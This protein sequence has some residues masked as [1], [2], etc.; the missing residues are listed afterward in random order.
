MYIEVI[1]RK[2]ESSMIPKVPILCVHG[3]YLGA[4]CWDEYF[5]K[6]FSESGFDAHALSLRGHGESDGKNS[7]NRWRL[8]DY[9]ADLANVV[10][11]LPVKPVLI[12][13]SVGGVVVQ[14]YLEQHSAPAGILL[15]PS[16]ITGMMMASSKLMIK[17]P[18]PY[19]KMMFTF[20]MLLGRPMFEDSFFSSDMPRDLV[21]TYFDRMGNESFRAFMDISL[22]NKPKPHK[23]QTP[24]LIIGG[25]KDTSIPTKINKD[26]AQ[27]Y[28]TKLEEFPIAH[29]MMLE[30]NWEMVAS[31]IVTWLTSGDINL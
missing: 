28:H 9:V 1:T 5:L 31:H 22:F 29:I 14:K 2:T 26:L 11:Q 8:A 16:P 24:M 18:I 12:G 3:G 27:A 25:E 21:R 7:I 15:A 23:I 4:W 17:Y 30:S 13:H 10:A 19:F 20:N 6:Y